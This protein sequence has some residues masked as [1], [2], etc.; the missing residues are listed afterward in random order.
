MRRLKAEEVE[1][2]FERQF[3]FGD[4][5]RQYYHP[6]RRKAAV[7][8]Q[9]LRISEVLRLTQTYSPGKRVLDLACA[10]GLFGLTLA[11]A[12]FDVT[13]VDLQEDFLRYANKRHTH[14]NFKTVHANLM[15]YRNPELF[16]CVFAGEVIEHVAFPDQLLKAAW[17]NLRPGGILIVTTPNGFEYG[18]TLPTYTQVEDVSV[19]V[20]KQFHWSDHLFLY[21]IE[22][23]QM[24]FAKQGYE[25][26]W[27]E[28][29]TSSYVSQI[30][31]VRYLLPKKVLQWMEVKTRHW[32]RAG[33]DTST[34]LIVAGRK[35]AR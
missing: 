11:E 28:K 31:A 12:G 8:A 16:D 18:S 20:P 14:G 10:Q 25:W 26:I 4:D 3:C 21:T 7:M 6:L 24:L 5:E 17:E 34:Q 29:Y 2:D 30:K 27:G 13:A 22:E 15:E 23:L 32:K 9:A 19:L 33:R 1:S 35:P